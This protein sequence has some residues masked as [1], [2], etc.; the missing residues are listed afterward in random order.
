MGHGA[1]FFLCD[2]CHEH[3]IKDPHFTPKITENLD[4]PR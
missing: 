3:W 4:A 2:R 1:Q